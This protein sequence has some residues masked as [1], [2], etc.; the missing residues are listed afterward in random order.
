ME[1]Y[2]DLMRAADSLR[3]STANIE[4][5]KR[6]FIASISQ[7]QVESLNAAD[8]K[9]ALTFSP[10]EVMICDTMKIIR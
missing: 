9:K 8:V 1:S 6:W 5:L 4:N 2:A 3:Q 7:A 10:L